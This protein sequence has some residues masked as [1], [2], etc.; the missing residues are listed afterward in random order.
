VPNYN[1]SSISGT[2]YTRCNQVV[3]N[4]PKGGVPSM[5]FLE[6]RFIELGADSIARPVGAINASFRA[7]G[8]FQL[9]DPTTG[10]PTGT[11]MTHEQVYAVLY[12]LYISEA[13]ARDAA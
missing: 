8:V 13:L 2:A 11:V 9:I 5:A 10:E 7:D 1:E 6:E 4:N 3:I 12:S